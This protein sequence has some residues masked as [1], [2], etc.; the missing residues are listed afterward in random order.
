MSKQ[1]DPVCWGGEL[2]RWALHQ[3]AISPE[4]AQPMLHNNLRRLRLRHRR[5][6]SKVAASL[7]LPP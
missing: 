4:I 5:S 6:K 7:D 2:I 3:E 1:W